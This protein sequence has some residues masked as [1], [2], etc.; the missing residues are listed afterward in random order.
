MRHEKAITKVY[1]FVD[2]DLVNDPL[3]PG[4]SSIIIEHNLNDRYIL[5]NVWPD[6]GNGGCIV[7]GSSYADVGLINEN[8]LKIFINNSIRPIIGTWHVKILV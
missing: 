2:S 6:S 1:S 5:I 7:L 3:C 8:S 4:F